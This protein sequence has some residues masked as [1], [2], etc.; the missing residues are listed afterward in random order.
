[1]QKTQEFQI[2]VG[3]KRII[4]KRKTYPKNW[5]TGIPKTHYD[6]KGITYFDRSTSLTPMSLDAD[7]FF[8]SAHNHWTDTQQLQALKFETFNDG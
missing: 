1:M 3:A 6:A 2:T 7:S 5:Y 4:P 8:V